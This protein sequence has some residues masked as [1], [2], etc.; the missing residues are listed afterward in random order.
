M[1]TGEGGSFIMDLIVGDKE[2]FSGQFP[3]GTFKSTGIALCKIFY[4]MTRYLGFR[5]STKIMTCKK[6]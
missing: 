5:D 3:R 2:D 4:R 1:E 6:S